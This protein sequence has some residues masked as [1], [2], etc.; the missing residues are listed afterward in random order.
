MTPFAFREVRPINEVQVW[1]L[2]EAQSKKLVVRLESE[3]VGASVAHDL[4]AAVRESDVISCATLSTKPLIKFEW[5]SP[6][7]HLDLIGSFTPNMREVDSACMAK[8]S[9]YIDSPD[10]LKESGDLI[11]PIDEGVL[12]DSDI[13]GTLTDLCQGRATGRKSN[14]G[15]TLFKAV[16]TGLSDLAAG[17]LAYH[18]LQNS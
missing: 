8:G 2:D 4:E 18:K 14:D 9:V 15:I 6:G 17:A 1:D 7:S 16:G 5:L 3:G 11:D 13:L 10:A 12:K